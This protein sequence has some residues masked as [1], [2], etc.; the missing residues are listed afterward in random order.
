M[1]SVLDNPIQT[2]APVH[3]LSAIFS[4]ISLLGND[5]S[6]SPPPFSVRQL[7]PNRITVNIKNQK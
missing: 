4:E 3:D 2:G 6:D 5:T 1:P 7:S